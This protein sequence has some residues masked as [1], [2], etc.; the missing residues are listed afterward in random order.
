MALFK[1]AGLTDFALEVEEN[2][3]AR[4]V[5]MMTAEH[6]DVEPEYMRMIYK[7][8]IL[9]DADILEHDGETI[10]QVVVEVAAPIGLGTSVFQKSGK[11]NPGVWPVRS[12]K[13]TKNVWEWARL[14]I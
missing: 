6:C 4:D 8:R 1:I 14:L 10:V 3:A 7:D 9:K 11:I 2:V 13:I 5:K 12:L